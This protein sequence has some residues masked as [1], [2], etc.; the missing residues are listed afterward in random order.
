MYYYLPAGEL[1]KTFLRITIS[2]DPKFC[3][4]SDYCL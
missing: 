3:I 1:T 4:R 2:V